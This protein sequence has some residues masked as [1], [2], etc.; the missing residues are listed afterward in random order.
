MLLIGLC[1]FHFTFSQNAYVLNPSTDKPYIVDK[2][3]LAFRGSVSSIFSNSRLRGVKVL[4][5]TPG[6]TIS[7]FITTSDGKYCL[8]I[9][10]SSQ[11]LSDIHFIFTSTLFGTEK[12]EKIEKS[13]I[14]TGEIYLIHFI[15]PIEKNEPDPPGMVRCF[16]LDRSH[17]VNC[18]C[19]YQ[20]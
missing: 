6:D 16:H 15:N 19:E 5:I 17:I 18:C 7:E 11:N 3:K 8:E 12:I 10:T 1:S 14:H 2:N 20:K 13:I 9:D 4:A